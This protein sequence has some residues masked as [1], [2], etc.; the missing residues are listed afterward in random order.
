LSTTE[1]PI[2]VGVFRD[3]ALAE[4]TVDALQHAGFRD[5][6]IRVWG[7]RASASDLLGMLRS[8]WTWQGA[9]AGSI[10]GFLMELGTPQEEA[11]YYQHE[12]EAS[13]FIVTVRSYGHQQEASDILYR[14]GAYTAQSSLTH[15]LHTVALREEVLA[16]ETQPV[17]VGKVFI[18]KE[19]ATEER[20]ITVSV[21]REEVVIERRP[22]RA[23]G[24]PPGEP[25]GTLVELA[26][27]ERPS[28]FPS[29]KNRWSS[30][31]GLS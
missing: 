28:G 2:A 21:Q 17:E 23:L 29:A 6:E 27:G 7:P 22:L 18:R 9:E 8:K 24:P 4:Q 14:A 25:I 30:R 10:S 3:R 26:A 16:A 20:M 15:D 12:A 31:S 11:D 13:R 1:R 19:V 5:D